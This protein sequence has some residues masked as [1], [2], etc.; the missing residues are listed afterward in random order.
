MSDDYWDSPEMMDI[1]AE[2]KAREIARK[3]ISQGASPLNAI[4]MIQYATDLPVKMKRPEI[5]AIVREVIKEAKAKVA[6]PVT[7]D[8]TVYRHRLAAEVKAWGKSSQFRLGIPKVDEQYGGGIYPGEVMTIVGAEGSMKTSLVLGGIQD[9]ISRTQGVVLYL[10]MDMDATKMETRRL[11]RVMGCSETMAYEHIANGTDDYKEAVAKL[12][13]NDDGRFLL[14]EGDQTIKTIDDLIKVEIPDV[15]VFDYLTCV[16][17]YRNEYEVTQQVM[18]YIKRIARE[19]RITFVLLNQ[20][21]RMEKANQ[22]AGLTDGNGMGGSHVEQKSDIVLALLKDAPQEGLKHIILT[23]GKNRRGTNGKSFDLE[24]YGQTM[25]F[26]GR[27]AEVM[28][29]KPQKPVFS[30]PMAMTN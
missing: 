24:Y 13:E 17:G 26:T 3:A 5:K 9:Y 27:S 11:M 18:P 15:V 12:E 20:M 30:L 25:E 23:V 8:P 6:E 7:T 28:R 1:V 2:G 4:R 22:R 10:S 21:S 19:E 29:E 14:V 16:Q